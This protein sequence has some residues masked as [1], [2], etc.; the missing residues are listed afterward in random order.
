MLL[1]AI[2]EALNSYQVCY[3]YM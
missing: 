2:Y 1:S 3:M